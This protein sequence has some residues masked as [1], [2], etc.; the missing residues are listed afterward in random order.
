MRMLR[1][2]W[3]PGAVRSST[4]V[5]QPLG[6]AV[7]RRGQPRRPGPDHDQVVHRL[8]QR[9]AEAEGLRQL[10]VRGVAQEQ[11]AAPGDHGRVG[12][13]HAELLEQLLA[14]AGRPPGP[15]R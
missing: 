4:T 14:P 2:A 6:G 3:P 7:D 8:L 9:P 10:E 15:A 13:G 1:P 11:L 5:L 12:L